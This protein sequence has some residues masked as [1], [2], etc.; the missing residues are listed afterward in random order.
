MASNKKEWLDWVKALVIAGVLAFVVRMFFFTPIVVDGLSMEPTLENGDHMIVNKISYN[1]GE[2]QRFDIVIFHATIQKDYIK[3]VIGLPGEH[4][5][6]QD[7]VL[8]IN[9][10]QVVEPF[11]EESKAQLTDKMYTEDF[12]LEQLPGG[13]ETIPEGHV[14][15][16]GDNRGDSTD[17]RLLGLIPYDQLV[18]K[19]ELLYWPLDRLRFV[20]D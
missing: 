9:N 17:S 15:V 1:F 20:K 7:D 18:G 16:L 8:Y 2:P 3:R 19:A 11:L 10:Q 6:V 14:L 4:V 12:S 13:Y 5:A